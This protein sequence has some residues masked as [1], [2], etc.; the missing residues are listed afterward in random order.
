MN[1]RSGRRLRRPRLS[2]SR[3]TVVR[4]FDP[5]RTGSPFECELDLE[6]A[7]GMAPDAHAGSGEPSGCDPGIVYRWLLDHRGRRLR[8]HRRSR[9][10]FRTQPY[11]TPP[12]NGGVDFRYVL[13]AFDNVFKQGNAEG[14]TFVESS[15]D[16]GADLVAPLNYFTT[17][18]TNPPSWLAALNPVSS[19][20]TPVGS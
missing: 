4:R 11:F 16:T 12:Y 19:R 15:G 18:P 7:G 17:P 13:R 8:R 2:D 1:L 20:S 14:I 9:C 5:N 10:T 3:S 6:Q